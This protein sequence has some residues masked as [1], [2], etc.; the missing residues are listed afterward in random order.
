VIFHGSKPNDK[1]NRW[2]YVT[3]ILTSSS[4]L[5][6]TT[7]AGVEGSGEYSLGKCAAGTTDNNHSK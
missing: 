6:N 5:P 4:L 7:Q 3:V 1:P 2:Q